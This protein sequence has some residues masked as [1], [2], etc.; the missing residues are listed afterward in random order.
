[1]PAG[2]SD[3]V[4]QWSAS[5]RACGFWR[6]KTVLSAL[7]LKG[8]RRGCSG[9]EG[10]GD[11]GPLVGGQSHG[12]NGKAVTVIPPLNRLGIP[13]ILVGNLDQLLGYPRCASLC[14]FSSVKPPEARHGAHDI[15]NGPP[16]RLFVKL[17][18]LAMIEGILYRQYPIGM[19]SMISRI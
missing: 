12:G 4:M 1:M 10:Y 16:S 19:M 2:K 9:F 3:L 8:D 18:H 15:R 11:H 6:V 5:R 14:R 13:W 17:N 7:W